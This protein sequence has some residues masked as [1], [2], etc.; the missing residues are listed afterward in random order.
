[1]ISYKDRTFCSASYNP[2][3]N[4]Q[5]HRFLSKK[6]FSRA[7]ELDLPIAYSDFSGTCGA[8]IK[9]DEDAT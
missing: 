5:C 4:K 1:M 2:C 6:E 8:M 3:V 7:D 9:S